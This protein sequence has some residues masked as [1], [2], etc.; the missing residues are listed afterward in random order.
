M[1]APVS[2]DPHFS[3]KLG[4]IQTRDELDGFR[5]QKLRQGPLTDGEK[6]AIAA[7]AAALHRFWSN[8]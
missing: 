5:D 7:K 6:A 8:P 1:S 4:S 2:S 3:A